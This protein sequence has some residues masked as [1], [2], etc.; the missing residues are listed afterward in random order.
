L[1]NFQREAFNFFYTE[2]LRFDDQRVW[3]DWKKTNCVNTSA[4][5][6]RRGG[7]ACGRVLSGNGCSHY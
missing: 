3:T 4:I 6:L 2:T 1:V 5:G 7:R